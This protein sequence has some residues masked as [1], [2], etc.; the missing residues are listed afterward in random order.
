MQ[1]DVNVGQRDANANSGKTEGSAIASDW[2]RISFS[3]VNL[4]SLNYLYKFHFFITCI[5][6]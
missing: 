3:A 5:S 4:F 1:S 2:H 6:A